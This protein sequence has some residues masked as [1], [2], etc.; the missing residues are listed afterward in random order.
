MKTQNT[1]KQK[2]VMPEKM[3]KSKNISSG[4]EDADNGVFLHKWWRRRSGWCCVILLHTDQWPGRCGR[5]PITIWK[6]Y[7]N[8]IFFSK[9]NINDLV[10]APSKLLKGLENAKCIDIYRINAMNKKY[11]RQNWSNQHLHHH[12][13]QHHN[14]NDV[15][16]IK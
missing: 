7:K 9:N 10:Q 13:H 3:K 11:R 5:L 12:Q 2:Q 8:K 15:F 14:H 4:E 6:I 16:C 1:A